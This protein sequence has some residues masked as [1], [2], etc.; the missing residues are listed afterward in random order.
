MNKLPTVTRVQIF[1]LLRE[2]ASMRAVF[3]VDRIRASKRSQS[4]WVDAGKLCAGFHDAK[5]RGAKARRV[6]VMDADRP[7]KKQKRG[8]Y[9][10]T[11]GAVSNEDTT[12]GRPAV[13]RSGGRVAG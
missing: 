1:N 3:P 2:G 5:V 4:C 9:R 8:P 7:A 12:A 13:S 11:A 6:Q 10:K